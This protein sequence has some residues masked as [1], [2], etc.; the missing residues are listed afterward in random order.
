[1]HLYENIEALENPTEDFQAY[2]ENYL[3]SLTLFE[4]LKSDLQPNALPQTAHC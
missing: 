2:E 3:H 4:S 1:M